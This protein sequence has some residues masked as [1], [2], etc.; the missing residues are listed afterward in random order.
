M[1]I[2]PRA[3]PLPSSQR[4]ERLDS[5]KNPTRRPPPRA[6][7]STA[8]RCINPDCDDPERLVVEDSKLICESCGTVAEDRPNLVNDLMFVLEA[9]RHIRL[10]TQGGADASHGRLAMGGREQNNS[11]DN[12]IKQGMFWDFP[13]SPVF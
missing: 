10:G 5:L 6:L 11:F 1:S 3:S 7:Q 13:F 8:T 2:T 12:T 4:R 9:G